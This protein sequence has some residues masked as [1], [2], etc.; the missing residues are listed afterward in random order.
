MAV[1]WT[2]K[3]T[4]QAALAGLPLDAAVK[5]HGVGSIAAERAEVILAVGVLAIVVTAPLGAAAVAATGE[6]L[7][8]RKQSSDEEAGDEETVARA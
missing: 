1:A 8:A 4:V 7:L 2:P 6:R 5:A 3:A